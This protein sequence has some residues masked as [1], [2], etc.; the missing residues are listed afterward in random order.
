MV[1]RHEHPPT[2]HKVQSP[3]ITD[4]EEGSDSISSEELRRL[5]I[6]QVERRM[7]WKPSNPI[8]EEIFEMAIEQAKRLLVKEKKK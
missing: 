5:T 2:T 6:Q 7:R 4:A 1:I 3:V 8:E